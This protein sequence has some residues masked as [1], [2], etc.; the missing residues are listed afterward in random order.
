M[1]S[2]TQ[3]MMSYSRCRQIGQHPTDAAHTAYLASVQALRSNKEFLLESIADRIPEGHLHRCIPCYNEKQSQTYLGSEATS[4]GRWNICFY[5][6]CVDTG[7]LTRAN[8]APRPGSWIISATTPLMYPF[9]SAASRVRCLAG[10]FL[11]LV[12]DVKT[13]PLPFLWERITRPICCE[14]HTTSDAAQHLASLEDSNRPEDRR[15]Q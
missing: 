8:G 12:W 7:F 11:F 3:S 5:K 9:L 4:V 6:S 2:S 14:G 1:Q 10:P 15:S 13:L